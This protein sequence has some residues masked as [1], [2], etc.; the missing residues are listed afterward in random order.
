VEGGLAELIFFC[1]TSSVNLTQLWGFQGAIKIVSSNDTFSCTALADALRMFNQDN[2]SYDCTAP[3]GNV[4]A[5]TLGQFHLDQE[6]KSGAGRVFGGGGGVQRS[7]A[8]VVVGLVVGGLL[9][10]V[11]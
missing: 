10:V 6:R 4:K 2:A 11:V 3:S 7:W 1:N 5:S 8:V 9:V